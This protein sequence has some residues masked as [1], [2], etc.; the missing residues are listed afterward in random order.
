MEVIIVIGGVLNL[1]IIVAVYS[2]I[3]KRIQKKLDRY[4]TLDEALKDTELREHRLKTVLNETIETITTK[5]TELS[6]LNTYLEKLESSILEKENEF[7]EIDTATKDLQDL[8]KNAKNISD[9]LELDKNRLEEI[10]SLIALQ[11][12]KFDSSETQLHD[13]MAKIDLYSRIEEF[14]DYGHFEMPEYLYETGERFA[15]EIKMLRDQQKSMIKNGLAVTNISEIKITG[16]S[17]IDKSIIDG[18]MKMLLRAFNIECDM[19]ISKVSPATFER[20][21]SQI[22]KLANDLEKLVASKRCGFNND[23]VNLKYQ[24]C[25]VQY[26]YTLKKKDEQE[27]QRLIREQMREEAKAEREY[28]EALAAAEKEEKLYRE[29]L[30]KAREELTGSSIEERAV[31]EA[32]IAELEQQLLEAEAKEQ[33]AKSLA[34]QTRRGH[35]YVISN[36]GSFGENVYKI[37]MTRRLDPMD[38]V[39]ELGDASVPF[40][41]DVHAI[42]FSD[43]A[44]AMETALHREFNKHRVNSVNLRKEFFKVD[45]IKIREAVEQIGD[46]KVD[47]KTTIVAEEFYE[48]KRLR[49]QLVVS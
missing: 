5:D 39:K 15:A 10:K 23:Y 8:S 37:G 48:S 31:A 16:V 3:S 35:V 26:Q 20:V 46:E 2:F 47:F 17:S 14:V 7:R 45:L 11:Q 29:L 22:E 32:K 1:I 49:D 24:E 21:L 33:R 9:Q 36:V 13:I 43:D 25:R 41:F 6:K 12:G 40:S 19:L 34:E 4:K 27:E 42:I 44:P 28:R 18:Q 30:E 38:R